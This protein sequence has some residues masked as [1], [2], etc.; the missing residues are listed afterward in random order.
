MSRWV[1]HCKKDTYDVY[2][3]RANPRSGMKASPW[4]NPFKIGKDGTRKEVMA[5]HR[6]WLK[7][8]PELL[9]RL[10]ELKGKILGCWCA[11]EECHG[12]LLSELANRNGS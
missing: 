10:P 1:V 4:A 5:K 12:D 2:I 9:A 8:Q 11:P 3:G 7:E 6:E